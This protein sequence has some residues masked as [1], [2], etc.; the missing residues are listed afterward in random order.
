[1]RFLVANATQDEAAHEQVKMASVI[2]DK[3]HDVLSIRVAFLV[4]CIAVVL[5]SLSTFEYPYVEESMTAWADLLSDA[6]G[7]YY[8]T[9]GSGNSKLQL[10]KDLR[11]F[12]NFYAN[13]NYGPFMACYRRDNFTDQAEEFWSSCGSEDS[14]Q[15]VF[16]SNFTQPIRGSWVMISS[17]PNIELFYNIEGPGR[18]EAIMGMG[19]ILFIILVMIVFSMILSDNISTV[20]IAPLERMLASVRHRC[21]Q[22]FKYTKELQED[23]RIQQEDWDFEEVDA[24]KSNEFALLEKAVSKLGTIASLSAARPV[25]TTALE[26]MSET[27]L[28]VL[29]WMQGR[30][31]GNEPSAPAQDSV[32]V[33]AMPARASQQMKA[34]DV[35]MYKSLMKSVPNELIDKLRT[36]DFDAFEA[37][38]EH[39]LAISVHVVMNHESCSEFV[40]LYVPPTLMMQF[41]V[42]CESEYPRNPFHCFSH[43][44]DVVYQMALYMTKIE[45]SNFLQGTTQFAILVAG[46]GHDLG[47]PGVNNTFLTETAHELALTYNDRSPLENFH[48]CKLFQILADPDANVFKSLNKEAYKDVRKHIVEAILH[49]DVTKHNEM[50]KE[51]SLLYQMS[52][53]AFASE[54]PTAEGIEILTGQAQMMLNA[55]LH[56]A[57]VGNPM[58]PWD[59][60]QKLA[61]LCMD[62]FFAQGD[63]EKELGIPVQM[64]N[65]RDKVNRANSQI[66]FIEFM[67]FPLCEAMVQIFPP[68]DFLAFHVVQ[69]LK[70]W[71]KLWETEAHPPADQLEKVKRRLSNISQKRD[72]LLRESTLGNQVGQARSSSKSK[73]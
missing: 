8:R 46:L 28:M 60:A 22:I 57:D 69:N 37:S 36:H 39:K 53:E 4:I 72:V 20:A 33:S 15:L 7:Q 5:P 54:V 3:L 66:G 50:V 35:E 70:S 11:R 44:V 68:L 21:A 64:L 18:L 26:E 73:P 63:M 29:N 62:E 58:K 24:E 2:S 30:Q 52:S 42:A 31:A 45:A 14:E 61:Y 40:R 9:E 38:H 16:E 32:R 55:I 6:A 23:Q 34:E 65:D 47:H 43:A 27:D 13:S 49:T 51:L 19:R 56:T 59:I 48:C 12:G 71:A 10:D 25:V 1:M 17:A 41:V 67:I